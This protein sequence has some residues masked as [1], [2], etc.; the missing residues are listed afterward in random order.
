MTQIVDQNETAPIAFEPFLHEA[1]DSV[2]FQVRASGALVNASV[3]RQA[4][5]YSFKSAGL[6]ADLLSIYNM[7]S[8]KIH[9]AVLQ[10][11][12]QGAREPVMLRES[13]FPVP[14]L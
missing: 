4:L 9:E 2:R 5:R 12:A 13:N 14:P 10:R 8:N 11:L 1:S 3:S 6:P 7:Y